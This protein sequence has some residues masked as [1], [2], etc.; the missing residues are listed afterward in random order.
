M[1]VGSQ[2]FLVCGLAVFGVSLGIV[3]EYNQGS[4]SIESKAMA[5][6]VSDEDLKKICPSCDRN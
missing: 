3:P 5:Q 6:N 4:I 1:K 2:F